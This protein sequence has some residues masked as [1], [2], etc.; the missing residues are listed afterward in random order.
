MDINWCKRSSEQYRFVSTHFSLFFDEKRYLNDESFHCCEVRSSSELAA[1]SMVQLQDK[2][3][4][5][6]L[7]YTLVNPNFRR[8]GI[9]SLI[10]KAV[11]ELAKECGV[12][13]LYAHVRENNKA[14][15]HS[16]LKSGFEVIDEGATFYKNG[17]K[18]IA[19]RKMVVS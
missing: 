14:S 1:V 3:D 8:R 19:L 9:N 18:K 12:S 2:H 7:L 6:R 4:R 5:I 10:K 13:Y 11:E 15:L 16:L 17:D